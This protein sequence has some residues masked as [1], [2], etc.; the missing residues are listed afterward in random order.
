MITVIVLVVLSLASGSLGL[1][2]L[3][4]ASR[5]GLVGRWYVVGCRRVVGV[6][7]IGLVDNLNGLSQPVNSSSA[8][9]WWKAAVER[10]CADCFEEI[11][12]LLLLSDF[13]PCMMLLRSRIDV[14]RVLDMVLAIRRLEHY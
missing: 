11:S 14:Q 2:T 9:D 13:L 3:G 10:R 5:Q 8:V 4:T 6:V 12:F 1:N 7:V